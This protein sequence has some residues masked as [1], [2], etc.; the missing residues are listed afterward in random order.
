[1]QTDSNQS[2]YNSYNWDS[3]TNADG[4]YIIKAIAYSL[5]GQKSEDT[6]TVNVDN[7]VLTLQ[8]SRIRERAWTIRK[9]YGKIDISVQNLGM[10]PVSKF[11][12]YR[13]DS[14]SGYQTITE[15]PGSGLSNGSYTYF[16][17]IPDRNKNY[18]YKC[19]AVLSGGTIIDVSNEI[20]I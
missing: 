19:E 2:T 15:I 11:I 20:N 17:K 9:L 12:L 14:G 3:T 7:I 1:M 4:Q 5:S 16:D 6:V 8:A 13:K 10:S 18:T